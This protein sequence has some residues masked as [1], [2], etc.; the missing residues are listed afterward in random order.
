MRSV[1]SCCVIGTTLILVQYK[2]PCADTDGRVLLRYRHD[3]DTVPGVRDARGADCQP[4]CSHPRRCRQVLAVADGALA[5]H[6]T[7][8]LARRPPLPRTPRRSVLPRRVMRAKALPDRVQA[9][10][11]L[12]SSMPG[13]ATRR[14]TSPAGASTA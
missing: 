6:L 2:A 7:H 14:Q 13:A 10:L 1:A 3:I 4:A 8:R 9:P 12:S 5:G 11:G